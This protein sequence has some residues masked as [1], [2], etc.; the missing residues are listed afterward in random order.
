MN[1]IDSLKPWPPSTILIL[2]DD[3]ALRSAS[4]RILARHGYRVLTAENAAHALEV[5]GGWV[6]PIDLLLCD[7]VLP[8]LS[9]REAASALMARRPRMKV[10]FTSGFRTHGSFRKQLDQPGN[11]FLSKPFGVPELLEAVDTV[12][13]GGCWPDVGVAGEQA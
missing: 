8:G 3:D 4:V 1:P 13:R 5:A 11:A 6:G 9:G 7:L 12:L 2:D 10:I